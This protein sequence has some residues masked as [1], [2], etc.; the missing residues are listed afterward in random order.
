M[1]WPVIEFLENIQDLNEDRNKENYKPRK[2]VPMPWYRLVQ[3]F[4]ENNKKI[5]T[6]DQKE[7]TIFG[8]SLDGQ[9]LDTA[10]VFAPV[11]AM[12][13]EQV[14][15]E[16]ESIVQALGRPLLMLSDNIAIMKAE[17]I[18]DEEAKKYIEQ[19]QQEAAHAPN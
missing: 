4:D 17:I 11:D 3:F 14:C 15:R 12:T 9:E 8:S 19:K 10:V 1:K 18:T 5:V 2:V 16:A 6:I 13:Q 7:N